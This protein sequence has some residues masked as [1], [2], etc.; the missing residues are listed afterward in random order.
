MPGRGEES[1]TP[2]RALG[3]GIVA[4]VNAEVALK[5]RLAPRPDFPRRQS[6]SGYLHPIYHCFRDK[7][8]LSLPSQLW[9]IR[10]GRRVSRFDL[11]FPSLR[12][13]LTQLS[14]LAAPPR[15]EDAARQ[16]SRRGRPRRPPAPPRGAPGC[17]A[18]GL[19]QRPRAPLFR[20]FRF[21]L[22][23]VFSALP[24]PSPC[25]RLRRRCGLL[26]LLLLLCLCILLLLLLD[27]IIILLLLL[28]LL[29]S[30]YISSSSIPPLSPS[31]SSSCSSP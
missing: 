11:F 22:C 26:L 2:G 24:P 31:P 8:P 7:S 4:P 1:G 20:H 12:R 17:T 16:P 29:P 13:E 18:G 25:R 27:I 28:L 23:N 19:R 21:P 9:Q 10:S 3:S 30:S 15:D 14:H 6:I 5:G